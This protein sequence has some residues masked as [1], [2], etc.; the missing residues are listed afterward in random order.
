LSQQENSKTGD[1]SNAG[2]VISFRR[3][4][5]AP[6]LSLSGSE[7]L[8]K[9]LDHEN[10][11]RLV[12]GISRVDLFWLI[13]KIGEDD[14]IP[15]LRLASLDQ[16]QYILDMELWR[17]DRMNLEQTFTWMDRFCKA[18]PERLSRWL[19]SED[20]NLQAHFY[21]F[22]TLQ[23]IIKQDDDFQ[24]PDGFITF[25]GL[26]YIRILDKEHEENIAHML[27]T[28]AQ[29]DYNRYQ[30]L[31]MGIAGVIAAEIEEDIYRLRSNR[32]AEDGYL[33]FEEA[34]SVY[35]HQRADLLKKDRSGY[36]L[37]DHGEEDSMTPIPLTPFIH[38]PADNLFARALT[39]VRDNLYLERL[40]M[41]FAGLC[42]QILS[43][44]GVSLEG[45]EILIRIS[46]KAAGYINL[47]LERLSEGNIEVS[48]QFVR[49]NPLISIF[50]VGFGL[51]LELKWEAEKWFRDAWF[52]K[53]GLPH[54]FWGDEWG[55]TLKGI[56][57]NRPLFYIGLKEEG[58]YRHFES[59]GEL[60]KC[61]DIIHRLI[62]LDGLLQDISSRYPMEI[63]FSRE[64]L[65]TFKPLL[66][67]FWARGQLKLDPG[68]L[69]LSLDEAK[70]FLRLIRGKEKNP[71]FTMRGMG[72]VFIRDIMSHEKGL[73]AHDI[74]LLKHTLSLL[75]QEFT[76][77]YAMVKTSDLDTRFTRLIMI[78]SRSD[79]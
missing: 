25:D 27:Q 38:A 36:K 71:P 76:E 78:E 46:R 53:H 41:E 22:N 55:G 29:Q 49:N 63:E 23:V 11:G 28:M 43:A 59:L 6:L 19:L 69:P 5:V 56:L 79:A 35:S 62:L 21:L 74:S 4:P 45:I 60:E 15:L 42:N 64:P 73:H 61:R 12:R 40:R 67:N 58:E 51:T 13:K 1:Q 52:L 65:L 31:F 8:N 66:I 14:S 30:A 47:G 54:Y 77:E 48:E 72:E 32:L 50:R 17:R 2:K 57:E 68:F 18:D 39:L 37:Y 26:Y 70:E 44:D 9:I 34:L 20:G 3:E 10:P 24:V 16:W 75:W 33:P 7:A